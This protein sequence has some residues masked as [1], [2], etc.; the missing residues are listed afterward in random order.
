MTESCDHGAPRHKAA[1]TT[2]HPDPRKADQVSR[3]PDA[4][5]W[6]N[7]DAWSTS[8]HQDGSLQEKHA[9]A[10]LTG[11]NTCGGWPEGIRLLVRRTKPSR[12]H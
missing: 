1:R 2:L 9:V 12:R 6:L 5:A 11:L 8:L 4:I 7:E 10:E 3:R